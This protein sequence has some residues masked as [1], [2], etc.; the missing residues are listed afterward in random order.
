MPAWCVTRANNCFKKYL[1]LEP[2]KER[3]LDVD[4]L[5]TKIMA[6]CEA[7]HT[8][9]FL[10]FLRLRLQDDGTDQQEKNELRMSLMEY[11][12]VKHEDNKEMDVKMKHLDSHV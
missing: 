3:Q 9:N 1:N 7:W 11:A 6:D 4:S 5:I 12:L 8:D 10:K 2:K